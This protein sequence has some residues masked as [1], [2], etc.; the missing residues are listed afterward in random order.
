MVCACP[1]S[2]C[3]GKSPREWQFMQRGCRNTDTNSTKRAPSLPVGVAEGVALVPNLSAALFGRE[4]DIA[5][6]QTRTSIPIAKRTD[7]RECFIQPPSYESVAC[8]FASQSQQTPHS[9][10]PGL[11]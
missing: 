5:A 2:P 7:V 11:G 1:S 3:R 8:G 6:A 9:R 10:Y 4:N